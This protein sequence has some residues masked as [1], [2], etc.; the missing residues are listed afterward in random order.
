MKE[1][2]IKSRGVREITAQLTASDGT[3]AAI[4]L[5]TLPEN[6]RIIDIYVDVPAVISGGTLNIGTAD[7]GAL[8]VSAL[9]TETGAPFHSAVTFEGSVPALDFPTMITAQ[10]GTAAGTVNITVVFSMEQDTRI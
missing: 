8:Y 2:F 7:D 3:A 5:F 6:A 10:M 9:S 1:E 4:D